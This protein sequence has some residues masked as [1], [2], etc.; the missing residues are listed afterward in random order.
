MTKTKSKKPN[1]KDLHP[2]PVFITNHPWITI[3]IVLFIGIGVGVTDAFIGIDLD[4]TIKNFVVRSG[5]TANQVEGILT[6]IDDEVYFNKET[7]D[8]ANEIQVQQTQASGYIQLYYECVDCDNLITSK[9]LERIYNFEQKLINDEDYTKY[10][11][12]TPAGECY[13]GS[14]ITAFF[15]QDGK[16][17]EDIE[18][19][20][21][22]L[23]NYPGITSTY[24]RDE[25]CDTGFDNVDFKSKYVSS[26]YYFGFPLE[27][28]ENVNDEI[29]EQNDKLEEWVTDLI[30][31]LV[32]DAN[33]DDFEIVYLGNGILSMAI[34][35]VIIHDIG[36]LGCSIV[37]VWL[38]TRFHTRS[39]LLATLGLLHVLLSLPL[40]YF[41]YSIIFSVEITSILNCLTLFIILGIGCDDIF[42]V[43]DHWKQSKI[44][45]EKISK[46]VYTRMNWTWKE[47]A[48]T[49]L[50][51]TCT[52]SGAF[53]GNVASTIPPIRYFGI[54]TGFAI[55][56]NYLLVITWFPA[57]IV[58]WHKKGETSCFYDFHTA[59]KL[60]KLFRIVLRKKSKEKSTGKKENPKFQD[61]ELRDKKKSK[62]KQKSKNETSETSDTSDTESVPSSYSG[63]DDRDV[64]ASQT[65][66][67]KSKKAKSNH[68]VDIDQLRPFERYFYAQHAPFIRKFRYA[69]IT[70]FVV[71]AIVFSIQASK[72]ESADEATNLF[73]DDHFVLRSQ[74]IANYFEA[75]NYLPNSYFQWGIKGLDREGVDPLAVEHLGKVIYNSDW[76]PHSKA[77]Q[78]WVIEFC[79]RAREK[80]DGTLFREGQ[81]NCFM[82]DFRDWV[83]DETLAGGTYTF[84]VEEDE[85]E[86]LLND[87]TNWARGAIVATEVV[88]AQMYLPTS[89]ERSI[90][91]DRDTGELKYYA[92]EFNMEM[93]MTATALKQ[94]E[95]F[96]EI[97]EFL[98]TIN[99]EAPEGMDMVSTVSWSWMEMLTDETLISVALGTIFVSVGV[100]YL[101]IVVSTDN[102][103]SSFFA[104]LSISGVVVTIV[105]MMVSI[106]WKLEL[107]TS[108]CLTV[109]VGISVDYVVH[110]CHA[111]TIS[112]H[113]TPFAK[114]RDA[115]TNL[116]ISVT[117]AAATT[118]ISTFIM[119]FNW[120]PFFL[121]FGLFIWMTII[122]SALWSFFFFFTL[123]LY[124]P[125]GDTGKLSVYFKRV[126]MKKSYQKYLEKKNNKQ[127][128]NQNDEQDSYS[129]DDDVSTDNR[130]LDSENFYDIETMA[131]PQESKK[132]KKSKKSKNSKTSKESKNSKNSKKAK[133][134]KNSQ[135]SKKSKKSKKSKNSKTSKKSNKKKDVDNGDDRENASV[136]SINTSD[137]SSNSV[138][139]S[140]NSSST[141]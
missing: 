45:E 101:I 141:D 20:A 79:E 64:E 52:A 102:I 95:F 16:Q 110:F 121:K 22:V 44:R 19:Y 3:I 49:M 35:E 28:H 13:P 84:P 40:S 43:L 72:L 17:V 5:D 118:L 76:K 114:L 71:M 138:S 58:L 57:I 41:V 104:I 117:A 89:Y 115:M 33:T 30:P 37:F 78:E 14:T 135:V 75:N 31:D 50:V 88:N 18:T 12:K 133:K 26:I 7:W 96:D 21:N 77:S 131:V 27:D 15:Y 42:I 98:D 105:G 124:G 34:L 132:S 97:E 70:I 10:C 86:P 66:A 106:G 8:S 103:I 90:G 122:S 62:K 65:K 129:V 99:K 134:S 61:L 83:T 140:T 87:F 127:M 126:F 91:F 46:N 73:P 63:S 9:Q 136:S 116:G 48:T 23:Y 81:G 120:S 38:Y 2:V 4:T 128:D 111:Y 94:R 125:T 119:F 92:V 36:L 53:F 137:A 67:N 130:Q 51:T 100:A 1:T 74:D 108:V 25:R 69:I 82:E 55:I 54:F 59:D 139:S 24:L 107:I 112:T 68:G 56:F 47:S 85:F 93:S 32:D 60:A 6:A 80:F 29:D 113:D 11:L 123:L 39:S 109:I